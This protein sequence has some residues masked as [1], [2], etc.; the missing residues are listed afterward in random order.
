M[1]MIQTLHHCYSTGRYAHYTTYPIY[2][3]WLEE[4][5]L[6]YLD[7][8]ERSVQEREG[9]SVAEQNKMLL[10]AETRLRLKFTGSSV[11]KKRKAAT[12]LLILILLLSFLIVCS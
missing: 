8:W 4:E 6:P 5:F 9:F 3:Q 11:L 2:I 10:S 7:R 1:Q 12:Q